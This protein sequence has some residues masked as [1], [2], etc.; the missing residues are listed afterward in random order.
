[1]TIKRI[2]KQTRASFARYR[3]HQVH[4]HDFINPDYIIK[5]LYT[6]QFVMNKKHTPK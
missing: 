2:R 3:L 4:P 1:M 5:C 6:V